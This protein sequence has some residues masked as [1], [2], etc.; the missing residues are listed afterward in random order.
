[1]FLLATIPCAQV[2]LHWDHA[3]QG[4]AE[5]RTR[6]LRGALG[7]A[8]NDDAFFHQHDPVTGKPL[9]RYPRIQYRWIN[10]YGVVVGWG[11][12][13]SRLLALPWFDLLLRLGEEQVMVSDAALTLT[14]S[15]FAA[16]DRLTNYQLKTPALLFN[17]DN[18]RRYQTLT[19][20]EQAVEQERLLV[21]GL[22]TAMRGLDVTFNQRLY[23]AFLNTKKQTCHYKGESLFGLSGTFVTNAVLPSGFAFGHGV[24]HGFGELVTMNGS[25]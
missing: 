14:Q 18:Y 8:F 2:E 3:V 25:V 17:Q 9:Y 12:A 15:Q 22:L 1:M 21:A 4:A 19:A 11:E 10:G 20:Q 13:A 16:G 24:S 5:I 23:A 7:A 6:Q